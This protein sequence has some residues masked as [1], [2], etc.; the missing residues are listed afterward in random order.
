MGFILY[1]GGT[2]RI[3]RVT[4][5]EMAESGEARQRF[6]AMGYWARMRLV[7]RLMRDPRVPTW[8]KGIAPGLAALYLLMPIDLIPDLLV[9][10]GQIDDIGVIGIAMLV[11]TRLLPRLTSNAVLLEHLELF[12]RR[13]GP[14]NKAE[15]ANV[16]ETTFRVAERD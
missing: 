10:L 16:V 8:A 13:G 5:G 14:W 12:T 6:D 7:S 9:G 2:M 4:V 1:T 15:P 3:G 11:T